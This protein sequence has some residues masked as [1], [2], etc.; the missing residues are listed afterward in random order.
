MGVR[1]C[2]YD[3]SASYWTSTDNGRTWAS[4]GDINAYNHEIRI[5][6]QP[7]MGK[8][9]AI[10]V[11]Y[12]LGGTPDDIDY[13]MYNGSSWASSPANPVNPA[14]TDFVRDYSFQVGKEGIVHIAVCDDATPSHL[15]HYW[16]HPDSADW[17]VDTIHTSVRNE[18]SAAAQKVNRGMFNVLQFRDYDS[19]LFVGYASSYEGDNVDDKMLYVQKWDDNT[20]SWGSALTVSVNDSIYRVTGSTPVP[21]TH[22]KRTYWG[23]IERVGTSY[24]YIIADVYDDAPDGAG[25][26]IEIKIN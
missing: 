11:V 1:H 15:I 7:Y 23:Y 4:Q 5:G 24:Q 26:V 16:Y 8:D 10:C 3:L 20:D 18:K 13:F 25:Q 19:A 14:T 9:S 12:D 22:G 6:A 21:A 17:N 2:A